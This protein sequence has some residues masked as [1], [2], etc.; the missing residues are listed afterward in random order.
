MAY[1]SG[2]SKWVDYPS[3]NTPITADRLNKIEQFADD[4]RQRLDNLAKLPQGSTTGDAELADIRVGADGK[5]YDNAGN[6]VREQF[7][8]VNENHE[9]AVEEISQLKQ[10]LIY[11]RHPILSIKWNDGYLKNDGTIE[12]DTYYQT[13]DLI[14]IPSGYRLI[15]DGF[16]SPATYHYCNY[17]ENGE[18]ESVGFGYTGLNGRNGIKI[19][20]IEDRYVRICNNKS[21]IVD[22]KARFE[23]IEKY[24][25]TIAD[26]SNIL[27]LSGVT[28][29]KGYLSHSTHTRQD[30]EV[31]Y[32]SSMLFI[33]KGQTIEYKCSGSN[34][35]LLLM[36]IARD[37]SYI[38][39]L[40]VGDGNYRRLTYT[41][42]HDMWVRICTRTEKGGN[43]VPL[44]EFKDSIKFYYKSLYH[45]Q[46]KLNGKKIVVI[47]DSLIYG[48]KL[49]NDV[50]WT[51]ILANETGAEVY[52]Y[53][54]NGNAISSVSGASGRPM[55]VR[56]EDIEELSVADII[57]IE[58]GAN[59]KNNNCVIG[60]LTDTTN[61]TF[62]GACNTLID[63]IR[64]LNSTARLMMMTTYPRY[65][66]KNALG[67]SE[68]DY[69][70]AMIKACRNKSVPCFDNFGIGI[71]FTNTNLKSWCD[72]G[73][74]LNATS[75]Q[76]FSPEGYE[77][78]YH[79]YKNWIE[80]F[81]D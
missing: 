44:E 46:E 26:I 1:G 23:N 9:E 55:S 3:T 81:I 62:I 68:Q 70:N 48:N 12:M 33:Q 73:I 75:N 52:N 40:V 28:F 8:K 72:E 32:S 45:A 30:S 21:Q 31:Y 49:G 65:P 59:D 18:F 27:P 17:S 34:N 60:E 51:K 69:A 35:A 15:F 29:V 24:P 50:T 61:D 37:S 16:A 20:A 42:D 71:D 63:G 5:T 38:E 58:G 2:N 76:H 25:T 13:S 78:I 22:T 7:K 36:E 80:S 43:Y 53:G 56:Y 74:Y 19:D 54:I 57:I 10:D 64:A 66:N 79:K 77:F 11:Y 67:K 6:A 41:A 4:N 47:G 14:H 39:S